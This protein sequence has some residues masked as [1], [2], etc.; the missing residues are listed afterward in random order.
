L[1]RRH[2]FFTDIGRK[3]SKVPK[4]KSLPDARERLASLDQPVVLGAGILTPEEH[5][6]HELRSSATSSLADRLGPFIEADPS[7]RSARLQWLELKVPG[8]DLKAHVDFAR[9]VVRADASIPLR[10]FVMLIGEFVAALTGDELHGL[11]ESLSS[12]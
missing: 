7:W 6:S 12:D 3:W 5:V 4:P 11:E 10:T 8:T 1:I 2:A 9:D